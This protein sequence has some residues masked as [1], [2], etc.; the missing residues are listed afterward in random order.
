MRT[1][2]TDSFLMPLSFQLTENT[3]TQM[4]IPKRHC[5]LCVTGW[6]YTTVI[7]VV[8]RMIALSE[9]LSNRDPLFFVGTVTIPDPLA[10]KVVEYASPVLVVTVKVE[11]GKPEVIFTTKV[12]P[13]AIE[14]D[15][16][17]MLASAIR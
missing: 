15:G 4:E 8:C 2:S 11:P 6:S 12:L 3:Y 7:V 14:L 9:I 1:G 13:L 10:A 17:V 5:Q 16:V